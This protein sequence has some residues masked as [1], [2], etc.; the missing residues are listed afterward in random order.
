MPVMSKL[1]HE[2]KYVLEYMNIYICVYMFEYIM[3]AKIIC[4]NSSGDSFEDLYYFNV[5]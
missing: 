4:Q 1:L 3:D 2:F 5:I